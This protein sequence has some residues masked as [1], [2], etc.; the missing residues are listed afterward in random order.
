MTGLPLP[1]NVR[2][3]DVQGLSRLSDDLEGLMVHMT[4]LLN[5]YLDVP[6]GSPI[7]EAIKSTAMATVNW[8][9]GKQST[10]LSLKASA[11][12]G[13]ALYLFAAEDEE[14]EATDE[15]VLKPSRKVVPLDVSSYGASFEGALLR[16]VDAS[17]GCLLFS[18]E[19][20]NYPFIL[21]LCTE[22]DGGSTLDLWFDVDKS[23]V[24]QALRFWAFVEAIKSSGSVSLAGPSGEVA[25]LSLN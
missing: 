22:D 13:E 21:R 3:Y 7:N 9:R 25:A 1:G 16:L 18:T 20:R 5:S 6:L 17:D 19:H 4:R 23:N 10:R 14:D 11:K 15:P 8:P 12:L 24:P 2:L